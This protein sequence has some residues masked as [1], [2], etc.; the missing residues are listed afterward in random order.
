MLVF[1]MFLKRV[2][3]LYKRIIGVEVGKVDWGWFVEGIL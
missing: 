3:S 1:R 2:L